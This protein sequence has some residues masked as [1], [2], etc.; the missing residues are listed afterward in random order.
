M[1]IIRP[2]IRLAADDDVMKKKREELRKRLVNQEPI[3][4]GKNGDCLYNIRVIADDGQIHVSESMSLLIQHTKIIIDDEEIGLDKIGCG[5][6]D[7][8]IWDICDRICALIRVA[9]FYYGWDKTLTLHSDDTEKALEVL[10]F[11]TKSGKDI[12]LK[13][14]LD[15]VNIKDIGV[16][17]ANR[18]SSIYIEYVKPPC[19]YA[20]TPYVILQEVEHYLKHRNP[21]IGRLY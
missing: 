8:K 3:T 12:K 13:I 21:Y 18:E 16:Y 11:P 4:I 14:G 20:G 9:S 2:T 1:E 6:E 7:P 15:I 10:L 5:M 17:M 19:G